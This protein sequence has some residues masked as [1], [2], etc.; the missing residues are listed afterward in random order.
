MAAVVAWLALK[1]RK[2]CNIFILTMYTRRTIPRQAI[3]M[4]N[5]GT[6]HAAPPCPPC[7]PPPCRQS[8]WYRGPLCDQG[9]VGRCVT[10]ATRAVW[11]GVTEVCGCVTGGYRHWLIGQTY[12]SAIVSGMSLGLLHAYY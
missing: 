12:L 11:D 8:N 3:F 1:Q 2:S 10:C 7:G 9:G 5:T 6:G 4:D